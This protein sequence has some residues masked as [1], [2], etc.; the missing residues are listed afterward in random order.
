MSGQVTTKRL[1]GMVIVPEGVIEQSRKLL[2]GQYLLG[3]WKHSHINWVGK[4]NDEGFIDTHTHNFFA[5]SHI[6][7]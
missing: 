7:R 5:V 3:T 2:Q 4:V 6:G 1:G